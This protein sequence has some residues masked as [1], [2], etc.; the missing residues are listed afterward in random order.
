[1]SIGQHPPNPSAKPLA[2]EHG[3][4]QPSRPYKGRRVASVCVECKQAMK[5]ELGEWSQSL[6][7][8]TKP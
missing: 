8:V 7:K 1:M 3:A 5:R 2:G 6:R 4:H